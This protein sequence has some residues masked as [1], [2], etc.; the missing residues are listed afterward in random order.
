MPLHCWLDE[1]P[2]TVQHISVSSPDNDVIVGAWPEPPRTSMRIELARGHELTMWDATG[3]LAGCRLELQASTLSVVAPEARHADECPND[4]LLQWIIASQAHS[5]VI[6]SMLF[7]D[8]EYVPDS[9]TSYGMP[10]VYVERVGTSE[11]EF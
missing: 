11:R 4:S 10:N 5:V 1:L 6:R 8:D 2:A 3:K 7:D 9:G